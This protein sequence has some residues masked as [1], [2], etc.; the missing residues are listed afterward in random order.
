M[1]ISDELGRQ[2]QYLGILPVNEEQNEVRQANVGSSN[3]SRNVVQPWSIWLSYPELTS[4]DHDIIKRIVRTKDE[5]SAGIERFIK[6]IDNTKALNDSDIE[7][8]VASYR[9]FKESGIIEKECRAR[10]YKKIIHI[11][12]ERIRQLENEKE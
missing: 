7:I 10:D 1:Q 4:F 8:L 2:L 6:Y 12:K 11:C 5:Y 3:Y 9:A